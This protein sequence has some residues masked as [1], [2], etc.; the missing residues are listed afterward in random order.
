MKKRL[1]GT[2]L[3]AC[4]VFSLSACGSSS[5]AES[6]GSKEVAST[7]AAAKEEKAAETGEKT[8]V[9]V[10]FKDDGQGE[11]HPWY[12]WLKDS[13][14]KWDKKDQIELEFA[15]ITGS[16]G[17]YYTKVAL[18]L[19]DKNT[20]PDVVI[21]DTFQLPNDVSAGY[22]TNL[23]SYTANYE[24]WNDGTYYESI[25]AGSMDSN[26]SVYGIPFST[27][28]RGIWY[29]K[30]I[31]KKAGLPEDW[32]PETWQD[33]LDACAA[34]KKN[35]PDVIPFWCNSGVATGE[36]TSMQTYE[37]LLYGTGEQLLDENGKWIVKSQA[38]QDTLQFISDVYTN[39]YGPSL[40]LILNGQ[41]TNTARREYIPQQKV[42][43][44]MDG[45]W[46]Y[47]NWEENGASPWPEYKEIMGLA[48]M[49]KQNGGGTITMSGG[50][51]VSIPEN[52]D[53]K[54]AAFELIKELMEPE[55]Y[56]SC[57]MAQGSI[58][59][60]ADSAE[61]EVYASQLFLNRATEILAGGDAYFRPQNE[62]YSVVTTSIQAM[63]ES[64]VSGSTPEEAMNQYAMDVARV[65]GD[66]NVVEK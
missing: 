50:W 16:E 48:A 56:T 31:F 32:N 24:P 10:T 15:P 18:Q 4:L 22:L 19:A 30:E 66:E 49:P 23:D 9:T 25:K 13:Y 1:I 2:A 28:A 21:E 52:S 47:S 55:N 42:A 11:N 46:I 41:A 33:I 44:V 5:E 53:A 38:I 40:S 29:N 37:M 34:V 43:M 12:V 63:V 64:V 26:G 57:V 8:K 6:A 65:V 7:E 27:D 14:E 58:A 39:G 17:D 36:A 61:D 20:C 3:T 62:Q 54:D 59:T 45:A 60:R 51:T 35:V